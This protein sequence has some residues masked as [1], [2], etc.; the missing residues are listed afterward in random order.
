MLKMS[1]SHDFKD[2]LR[3]NRRILL[4]I[5][6]MPVIGMVIAI[7]LIFWRTPKSVTVVIPIIVFLIIQYSLL[8][9]WISKKMNQ[10]T[11]E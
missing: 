7:P 2:S 10:L 5:L 9:F 6:M 3:Q 11:A 8:V 4:A 1:E